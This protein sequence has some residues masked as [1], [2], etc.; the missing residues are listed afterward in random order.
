MIPAPGPH[1]GDAPAIA[2]ALGVDAGSLLDLSLTLNPFAPDVGELAGKHLDELRR[3][4]DATRAEQALAEALRADPARVVLTNG[5]AEAISL[6]AQLVGGGAA[7]EP[8]FALHP[9][10]TSGPRWRSNPHNPTGVLA[11]PH[12]R[13]GVWDEAFYPLATG[14]WT[15][16][17]AD[18]WIVGSL[19]KVFACPG[20]RAGYVVAPNAASAQRVRERRPE[21]SVNGI[22][23]A[24]VPSMIEAAD[25]AGWCSAIRAARHSLV[26][27]LTQHGYVPLPSDSPWVL[28][29]A[30]RGM[31]DRLAHRGVVV[32]DCASFGLHDHVRIAVPDGDGLARL[33]EALCAAG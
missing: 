18:T 1:G 7:A 24:I 23:C 29:P 5:G 15:R 27:A 32:R 19:T 8:E 30:A 26:E 28:V 17:D 12:Q 2:A 6:V 4:P 33:E 22:A 9:R 31:R 16:G 14:T 20:L 21:W 13:A 25:L 3:Y 11:E 10:S